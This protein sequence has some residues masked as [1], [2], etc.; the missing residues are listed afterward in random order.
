MLVTT[1]SLSPRSA[2][3]WRTPRADGSNAVLSTP[4]GNASVKVFLFEGIMPG[5]VGMHDHLF[6]PMGGAIFGEIAE[7]AEARPDWL[8]LSGGEPIRQGICA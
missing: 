5:L 7:F 4:K 3:D 2:R 6:Y 8:D 1:P